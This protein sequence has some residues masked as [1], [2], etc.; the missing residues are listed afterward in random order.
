MRVTIVAAGKL[1]SGP[2]HDLYRRYVRMIRWPVDLVEI[3]ERK[4]GA[5]ERMRRAIPDGSVVVALDS[6]GEQ[7]SSETLAKKL[8]AWRDRGRDVAFLIGGA[9]G[10]DAGLRGDADAIIAF[11]AV[12]WPHLLARALLAEQ[13]YRAHSILIGHPYHRGG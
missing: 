4:T 9:D 3:D 6:R 5:A 12:T 8:A 7:V 13:L 11:G 2:E 10:L 1:K